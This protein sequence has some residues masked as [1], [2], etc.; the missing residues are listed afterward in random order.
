MD[1]LP[2]TGGE[3]IRAM[4]R[5]ISHVLTLATA[6]IPLILIATPAAAQ[7]SPRTAEEFNRAGA[8]ER[9]SVIKSIIE[10]QS[11]LPASNQAEL[12]REALL[13]SDPIMRLG[14]LAA[15]VSRRIPGQGITL[16]PAEAQ[17]FGKVLRFHVIRA[18]DDPSERVRREAVGALASVDFVTGAQHGITPDTERILA[19]RFY[20]DVDA[21]VRA[22]IVSGLASETGTLSS[23]AQRVLLDAF[24][25]SD[26]RVRHTATFGVLRLEP[27]IGL[28]QL[29]RLISD[30]DRGVRVQAA[31]TIAKFG[32]N[33]AQYNADLRRALE[34]E[35]DAQVRE[36]LGIALRAVGTTPR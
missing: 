21:G 10:H 36:A 23:E 26:R 6:A 24:G 7:K 13:D 31:L 28:E 14:G 33:G 19:Q 15:I 27:T 35:Q 4:A 34:T 9:R 2:N 22:R 8:S 18:L 16:T 20:L 5:I 30:S 11:S 25:D 1:A 29:V 32:P 17:L 3:I 12:I